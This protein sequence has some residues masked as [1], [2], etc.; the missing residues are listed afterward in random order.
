VKPKKGWTKI[1]SNIV[2]QGAILGA[3][4]AATLSTVIVLRFSNYF[5]NN[6]VLTSNDI[7]LILMF[8]GLI[9]GIVNGQTLQFLAQKREMSKSLQKPE[10]PR[11]KVDFES[12]N[13][14][15][16][17]QFEAID[18]AV[19]SYTPPQPPP[20][21]KLED[22]DVILRVLQNLL[23][24]ASFR[25]EKLPD[26]VLKQIDNIA[27]ILYSNY[28]I[29]TK[30]YHPNEEASGSTE[31]INLF[32]FEPSLVPEIKQPTT[33]RPALIKGEQ[34]LVQG[35]VLQPQDFES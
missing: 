12:L 19:T 20:T 17:Q 24:D 25:R 27:N 16:E 1:L 5:N 21:P 3:F 10:P 35:R 28:Q 6:I 9:I 34:V 33:F 26:F 31:N 32:D 23:G 2:F 7:I 8:L 11:L 18:K 15:V 13:T 4:I 30:F 14:Y 29:E 22:H